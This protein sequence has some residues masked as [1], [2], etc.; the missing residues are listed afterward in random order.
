MS[1]VP[2]YATNIRGGNYFAEMKERH[3]TAALEQWDAMFADHVDRLALGMDRDT[4]DFTGL[5]F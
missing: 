5:E 2:E 3:M 1:K 4:M